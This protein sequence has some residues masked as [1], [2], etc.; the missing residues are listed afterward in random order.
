MSGTPPEGTVVC[1]YGVES[2]VFHRS[3]QKRCKQVSVVKKMSS[4][5]WLQWHITNLRTIG[6]IIQL[7][8]SS[9]IV[10]PSSPLWENSLQQQEV[11]KSWAL[12]PLRPPQGAKLADRGGQRT[13]IIPPKPPSLPQENSLPQPRQQAGDWAMQSGR[14]NGCHNKVRLPAAHVGV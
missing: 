3:D 10:I 2:P 1:E 5:W 14:S 7:N 9:E 4:T 6:Q 8:D 12:S 13:I 11:E